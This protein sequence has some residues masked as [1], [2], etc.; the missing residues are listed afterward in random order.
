MAFHWWASLWA[1]GHVAV[2][3]VYIP[4][5]G[6][7]WLDGRVVL[8]KEYIYYIVNKTWHSTDGRH[9]LDGHVAVNNVYIPPH[10]RHWLDGRVVLAKEYIYI[11]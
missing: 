7:H 8:A 3:N 4:P 2:N 5:D 1:N 9:W 6:R 11:I 10:G